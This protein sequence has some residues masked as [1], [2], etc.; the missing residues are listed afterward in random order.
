MPFRERG[1]VFESLPGDVGS[2]SHSILR[3]DGVAE[4]AHSPDRAGL[5]A[6]VIGTVEVAVP[7][8]EIPLDAFREDMAQ[9]QST[10]DP[11]DQL[12]PPVDLQDASVVFELQSAGGIDE[13]EI[14]SHRQ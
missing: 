5:P 6:V 9:V 1:K 3:I 4:A 8:V 7:E 13:R 12:I 11:R 14:V 10:A 2:E